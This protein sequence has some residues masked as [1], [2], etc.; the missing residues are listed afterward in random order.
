MRE[1]EQGIVVDPAQRALQHCCK[2]QIIPRHQRKPPE[3][4]Q[5]HHRYVLGKLQP[6]RTR[7][8][9]RPA[10]ELP[11]DLL[12]KQIPPPHQHHHIARVHRAKRLRLL[13]EHRLAALDPLG[14]AL[15]DR[16]RQRHGRVIRSNPV[17]GRIPHLGLGQVR[18]FDG[19][20]QLDETRDIAPDRY[21]AHI[22]LVE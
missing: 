12:G 2:R 10:L 18:R 7:D 5:I 14:N 20:P 19:G 21:M 1:F 9:D 3:R 13:V 17:L 8:R 22:V 4:N 16:L 6:V 15:R 11:D